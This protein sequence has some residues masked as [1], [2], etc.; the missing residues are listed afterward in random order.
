M[1]AVVDLKRKLHMMHRDVT[2]SPRGAPGRPSHDPSR[3]RLVEAS[4]GRRRSNR[5][6]NSQ[7][8]R[9]AQ[10]DEIL[11]SRVARVAIFTEGVSRNSGEISQVR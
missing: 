4:D 3:E 10:G 2:V 8:K 7:A 1:I 5:P 6:G 11:E 9:T